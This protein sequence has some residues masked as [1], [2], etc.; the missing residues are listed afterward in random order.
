MDGS[1]IEGSHKAWNSLQRAQPSGIEVYS[2]LAHDFFL[3]R[4]IRIASSRLKNKREVNCSAFISSTYSSHHVRLVNHT[5]ELFNSL[6]EQETVASKNKLCS[7]P[8][9]PTIDVDEQMGLVKS[10]HSVT[11]GGLIEMKEEE[12][13]DETVLLEDIDAEFADSNQAMYIESL[14]VTEQQTDTLETRT[15]NPSADISTAAMASS[16]SILSTTLLSSTASVVASSSSAILST[17][18]I[19]SNANP[20]KSSAQ[21][22]KR[23]AHSLADDSN[24]NDG[25]INAA[26]NDDFDTIPDSKRRRVAASSSLQD[27]HGLNSPDLSETPECMVFECV[28]LRF[29]II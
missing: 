8:I 24:L 23:K 12:P 28:H 13:D 6:Y 3:R 11:F 15:A 22:Q 10:A 1:R 25:L 7:A 29:E 14:G 19:S 2:G 18:L 27:N 20:A 4:N 9:L 17:S 26:A 21:I 16:S 5:A